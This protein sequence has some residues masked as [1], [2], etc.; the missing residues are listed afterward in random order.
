ML[1]INNLYCTGTMRTG[2][3]LVSNL[4]STHKDLIIIT[5]II[6]FFRYIYKKYDPINQNH[7]LYRLSAELSLRLKLRDNLKIDKKIFYKK[8]IN[9]NVRTYGGVYSSIFEVLLKK[10]PKKKFIGEYANGEW[11]SIADFLSFDKKNVA[12]HVIR[13]PRAMLSSWKKITFSKGHKYLNSIFNWIDYADSYAK[14]KKKFGN[15]RY[16]LIKFEDIHKNPEKISR[17]LCNFLNLSFDK[18]MIKDKRWK[19]LLKNKFNYINETAY[20]EKKKVYGFSKNRI[21]EWKKNLNTWEINLVNH[22][23]KKRIKKLDYKTEKIDKKLLAQGIYYIKKD[24]FLNKQYEHFLKYDK[25]F[26]YSLNDPT[27]PKNWESRLKPG[28]KFIHS[29][30]YKIYKKELLNIKK[31]SKKLK[32]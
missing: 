6:H 7:N 32:K 17:K 20:G 21:Y 26:K 8:F 24:K 11:K 2:G 4:L 19:S 3:S 27:D 10:I 28:I 5:D 23:C 13:D 1:K 16:L 9:N 12:V 30:E 15:K 31:Y 14:Y 25:G 18:N 22:L 29:S